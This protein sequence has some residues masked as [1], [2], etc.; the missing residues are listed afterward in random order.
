MREI[1][2]QTITETVA[3]LCM[4]SNNRLSADMENAVRS[5]FE[6]EQWPIAKTT[7]K[8]LCDNLDAARLS[9]HR[10]GLRVLR[11][12]PGGAHSGRL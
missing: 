1:S 8:T 6:T 10:H 4:E 9:G 7:L 5:A 2:A 11:D 12:R 3:R